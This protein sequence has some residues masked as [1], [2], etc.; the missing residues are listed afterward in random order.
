ML[1]FRHHILYWALSLLTLPLTKFRRLLIEHGLFPDYINDI[2]LP[3]ICLTLHFLFGYV[4]FQYK[5]AFRQQR[6]E[7]FTTPFDGNVLAAKLEK[8]VEER[9]GNVKAA[10]VHKGRQGR[11]RYVR[12]G[13]GKP[14]EVQFEKKSDQNGNAKQINVG[15][16]PEDSDKT[17]K[18]FIKKKIKIPG[19]EDLIEV[20]CKYNSVVY[21]ACLALFL[22]YTEPLPGFP[23]GAESA[24]VHSIGRVL[25]TFTV[26]GTLEPFR[27]SRWD[28][29]LCGLGMFSNC[30]VLC[31]EGPGFYISALMGLYG[32]FIMGIIIEVILYMKLQYWPWWPG[33]W[34]MDGLAHTDIFIRIELLAPLIDFAETVVYAIASITHT[35]W[36]KK[37]HQI[38]QRPL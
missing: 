20:L 35:G 7:K 23:E 24:Y 16:T 2:H 22:T 37:R 28:I 25:I 8:V 31:N 26:L 4:L 13:N 21:F 36:Y 11:K 32:I 10:R 17:R 12:G 34:F 5:E 3:V 19:K 29:E 18:L 15:F 14:R 27:L 38:M 30:C 33:V 6:E 9:N 1:S